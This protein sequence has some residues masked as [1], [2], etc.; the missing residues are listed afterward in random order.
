MIPKFQLE[1]IQ[2]QESIGFDLED[3]T[4]SKYLE[5]ATITKELGWNQRESSTNHITEYYLLLRLLR[6]KKVEAH[7][8]EI[9]FA[10]LNET[11]NGACL[12][13]KSQVS[14]DNLF[15]VTDIEERVKKLE[16]G[17]ITFGGLYKDINL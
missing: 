6:Q 5:I 7:V 1:V 12:N 3:F 17:N 10:K 11:L 9:I 2:T 15:S 4:K 16:K 14:M 8:R 13:L